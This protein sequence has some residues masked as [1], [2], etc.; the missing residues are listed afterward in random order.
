MKFP[1]P[2]LLVLSSFLSLSLKANAELPLSKSGIFK[3]QY[4][5]KS[6]GY[7]DAKSCEKDGGIFDGSAC[8]FLE[9][10]SVVEINKLI[11][12]RYNLSI[13]SV[14]TNLHFCD[15]EGLAFDLSDKEI[16]SKDKSNC[17]ITIKFVNDSTLRVKTNG[18]CQD[19]CGV[20]MTLDIEKAIRFSP[21]H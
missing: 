20:N 10:G 16:F 2:L 13:S 4:P 15:Y 21:V 8:L 7:S 5:V 17:E 9:G 3:D 18:Q 14:G 11:D 12:G 6:Y 1:I 19:Y